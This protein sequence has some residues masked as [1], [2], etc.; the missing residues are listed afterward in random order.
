MKKCS[1]HDGAYYKISTG[2]RRYN[3]TMVGYDK[4]MQEISQIRI[5]KIR[6]KK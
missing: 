6:M 4:V 1:H 5:A 3:Y 2:T